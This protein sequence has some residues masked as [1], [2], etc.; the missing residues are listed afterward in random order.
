MKVIV[1][2]EMA[3][4]HFARVHT[5]LHKPRNSHRFLQHAFTK[6]GRYV[7]NANAVCNVCE[8]HRFYPYMNLIPLV[9]GNVAEIN[10][11]EI[12]AY[13]LSVLLE[14]ERTVDEIMEERKE[15]EAFAAAALVSTH[16]V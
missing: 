9:A 15:R 3:A 12:D 14:Q 6:D 13:N 7:I 11:D 16:D 10:E 1:I 8:N 4:M 5:T 2:D